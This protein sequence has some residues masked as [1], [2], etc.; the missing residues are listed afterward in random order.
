VADLHAGVGDWDEAFRRL[1]D[2]PEEKRLRPLNL[3]DVADSWFVVKRLASSLH[4][5]AALGSAAVRDRFCQGCQLLLGFSDVSFWTH[6]P[7]TS[8][9]WYDPRNPEVKAPAWISERLSAKPNPP[10]RPS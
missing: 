2:V 5:L 7:R 10:A 1:K 9:R 4:Q 8:E 3:D 6:G